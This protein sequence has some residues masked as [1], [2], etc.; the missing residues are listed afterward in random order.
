VFETVI[1]AF[2]TDSRMMHNRLVIHD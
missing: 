1:S 2:Y